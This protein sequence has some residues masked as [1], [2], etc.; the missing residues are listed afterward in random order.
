MYYLSALDDL[1]SELKKE[2]DV[3]PVLKE[4]KTFKELIDNKWM[5]IIILILLSTEWILR[6]IWGS[7]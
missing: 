2:N 5:F 3:K 4:K 7:I 1:V 6:K